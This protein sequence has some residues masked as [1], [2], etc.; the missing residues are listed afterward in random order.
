MFLFWLV[1]VYF[2]TQAVFRYL[3]QPIVTQTHF[4]KKNINEFPKL[5]FCANSFHFE[6][7]PFYHDLKAQLEAD[8]TKGINEVIDQ[9]SYDIKEVIINPAIS[10]DDQQTFLN[11]NKIWSKVYHDRYGLCYTLDI[12]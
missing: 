3:Q 5:T 1:F 6:L 8:S 10:M 4:V 9:Y 12:R 11:I 7:I 2:T